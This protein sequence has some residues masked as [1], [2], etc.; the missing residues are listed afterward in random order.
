M[1][2]S[3]NH[4]L[5]GH[6]LHS[7]VALLRLGS[8]LAVDDL[9]LVLDERAAHAEVGAEAVVQHVTAHIPLG[10]ELA[11]LEEG[12]AVRGGSQCVKGMQGLKGY[13]REDV[14][15]RDG[16]KDIE[17]YGCTEWIM[18]DRGTYRKDRPQR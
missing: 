10:A 13:G 3:S 7:L 4:T 11:S 1:R 15:P 2:R 9:L 18:G 14:T 12:E 5:G 16:L 6:T 8:G 17:G